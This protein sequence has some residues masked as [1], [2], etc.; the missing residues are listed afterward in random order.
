LYTRDVELEFSLVSWRD[1]GLRHLSRCVIVLLLIMVISAPSIQSAFAT[2]PT[3]QGVTYYTSDD[4]YPSYLH[5][6]NPSDQALV[7]KAQADIERYRKSNITITVVDENGRP[8]EGVEVAF[9]QTDHNFLFGFEDSE[10]YLF[11]TPRIMREA[12]F[13]LFVTNPIW[14]EVEPRVHEYF[15]NSTELQHLEDLRNMGFRIEATPVVYHDP[16]L[17]PSFLSRMSPQDVENETLDYVAE[18]LRKIPD[19]QIYELSNEANWNYM[20]AGLSIDEYVRMIDQ[21]ASMIRAVQPNA[22]LLVNTSNTLGEAPWL[23]YD[24]PDLRPYDWYR[25][26]ISRNVDIDAVGAQFRPGYFSLEPNDFARNSVPS[27]MQVSGTLDRFAALGKRVHIAEFAVPSRQLPEVKRYGTSDWNDAVQAAY[28]EGFYTLM[29]SK[30]IADSIV[31]WFIGTGFPTPDEAIG[32]RPFESAGSSLI[33]KPSYYVL[34]DL[35]TNRWSTRGMG[36]TDADGSVRIS[37]FSGVY[38][39][40]IS[41][42]GVSSKTSIRIPDGVSASYKVIFDRA[43]AIRAA[44]NEKA[45]LRVDA[46]A[47]MQELAH[48]WQWSKTVNEGRGDAIRSANDELN[49]LFEKE[50][51]SDVIAAGRALVE[52]PFQMKMDGQ[53]DD[54]E[55]F[56]PLIRNAK[57]DQTPNAQS[58]TE[59]SNLYAFADSS[60]LYIGMQVLGDKPDS[61]AT[62]KVE[63]WTG[64][65]IFHVAY[66]F[67][68]PKHPNL[69]QCEC[70][71]EPWEEGNNTYF[72]CA[73][74]V[75]K[76]VEMRIPLRPLRY[77]DKIT[78]NRV[79]ISLENGNNEVGGYG[80]PP[81]E[82]P[83]LRDF[84]PEMLPGEARSI[85]SE[86]DRTRQWVATISPTISD[87]ILGTLN[88]LTSLYREGQYAEVVRVGKLVTENPLGMN[89]DGRLTDLEGLSP[90]L[91]DPPNDTAPDAPP[92]TDLVALYA[93]ADSSNLYLGVRVRGDSPNANAIFTVEIQIE[94]R[95]HVT[96]QMSEGRLY[97]VCFQQPWVEGGIDFDCTCAL[98][99]MVEMR[100]P[101]EPFGSLNRILVTNAWI[102]HMVAQ[103]P[104]DYDGY[105]SSPV[106]IPNLRS[107]SATSILQIENTTTT[108]LASATG[109]PQAT[110]VQGSGESWLPYIAAICLA[111][112]LG[113][114]LYRRRSRRRE[115]EK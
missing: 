89:V 13:N 21:A 86:L 72:A 97:C 81:I 66:D 11:D 40:T 104:T 75:G 47:I 36:V 76:I 111:I 87:R 58:G 38:N 27:L 107:F 35:I 99:E 73:Y 101:L 83:S 80:G 28:V 37:G 23:E 51:Y 63:I 44:E 19:A 52:N 10:N 29:F 62:F 94:R 54:F 4:A 20:R 46:Q 55:G 53:I 42:N 98:G 57:G 114:V 69:R 108:S 34:K 60:N 64:S 100:V 79:W 68:E 43:E 26:L 102:W 85:L 78:L 110:H 2:N 9:N 8:L 70:W 106:E 24:Y 105:E 50:R 93:F 45:K 96:V 15:W 49:Q 3:K 109:A 77:P 5:L 74:A 39:L 14:A 25:L 91:T 12:G 33:P 67:A 31:W 103:S 71:Q 59:L 48:A 7:E 30:P 65:R 32:P 56:V 82:I 115:S 6:L 18:L 88:N 1:P 41:G 90:I 16:V 22:T 84:H 113:I 95:Y 61:S 112:V 92:G 17:S